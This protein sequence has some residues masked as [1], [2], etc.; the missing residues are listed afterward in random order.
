MP[1][2]A[3]AWVASVIAIHGGAPGATAGGLLACAAGLLLGCL[4]LLA[5]GGRAPTWMVVPAQALPPTAALAL[6]LLAAGGSLAR[7]EAGPVDRAVEA[8]VPFTA[9]LRISGEPTLLPPG[10]FGGGNRYLVDADVLGGVLRGQQFASTTPVVVLAPEQWAG[11]GTGETVRVLGTA[12]PSDRLG[13]ATAVFLP[14]GAPA[15]DEADGWLRYTDDLRSSFR[16]LSRRD[17]R[18]GGLLPGMVLGDRTGLDPGLAEAMKTTG[19]T[20]LTAVSGA[21]CSYVVAFAFLALRLARTPR[22]PAAVGAVLAL[23]GFVMLVRPEPSVLRA[24]VMGAI[25]VAAVLSGRGRVSLTLLLVSVIILLATDP[26]LSVSY[27]FLLSVAATLGLITAGP[28][29]SETLQRVMPRVVAQL[30]AIP[31]TAQL[32]CTPILVLIQPTLPLYSLP[33]NVLAAPAVPAITLLGMLAVLALVGVPAL[34]P[35]LIGAGQWGTRWVAGVADALSTGPGAALPWIPGAPGAGAAALVSLTTL[36]VLARRVPPAAR[37]GPSGRRR[38]PIGTGPSPDGARTRHRLPV[39]LAV[40][41]LL[42]VVAVVVRKGTAPAA[43]AWDLAMCDVGQ[44]D[45]LVLQTTPGHALVVDAGPDPDAM[46]RCLDALQVE[47]IDAL[48]LTHLH[49]DHYGGIE[50]TLRGRTLSTLY[51][52]T[53]EDGLPGV[54]AATAGASGVE[55]HR[56]DSSTSLDLAPLQID[57]LW[58]T[59]GPDRAEENNASAVLDVVVPSAG[60]PLRILL[61]GDLEEDAAAALLRSEPGLADRGV[62]VLKI[63]H[64]GASNGGTE[65]I[66]AVGPRLA[67]ISAGEGNDYGHPH[68]SILDALAR[69][70]IATVRTDQLGS[71]T[72]DVVGTT[73][74]VR[75]LR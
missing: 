29:V 61:T 22:L 74:E 42:L 11:V 32:F 5:P 58:P 8:G 27:A 75:P 65:L 59:D 56:L 43:G 30:L 2:A 20:H 66:E 39:V 53:G 34:A 15:V 18:D 12:R 45:G 51:Y 68:Q 19:L 3:A 36:L 28:R 6:V 7:A 70:G 63:A 35:P 55:P 40:M 33:A 16:E 9:I 13:R 52:S 38:P 49:D 73:V 10:A 24:A 44:G 60:R 67:L 31:L 4:L 48:V 21:N 26:W 25:G 62:D 23:V 72:V 17:G 69:A 54:V 1:A 50:G 47:V 41:V 64:H 46:D 57:V 14:A 37:G 71:F